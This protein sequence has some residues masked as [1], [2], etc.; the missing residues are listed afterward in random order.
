MQ[1]QLTIETKENVVRIEHADNVGT[2]RYIITVSEHGYLE[3]DGTYLNRNG[4]SDGRER[5]CVGGSENK[6]QLEMWIG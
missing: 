1:K 3:I 4:L 2:Q 5:L 6:C